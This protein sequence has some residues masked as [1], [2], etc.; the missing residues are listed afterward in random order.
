MT[1]NSTENEKLVNGSFF[2]HCLEYLKFKKGETSIQELAKTNGALF[3]DEHR[4][5]P[6]NDLVKI[7]NDVLK[8]IYG[9]PTS[10]GYYD[11]G[12][13]TFDSFAHTLIGATLTNMISSP[14]QIVESLQVLWSSVV[15]F[16]TRK[17]IQIDEKKGTALIEI[18]DDPRNPAYIQGI[19]EAALIKVKASHPK[20]HILNKSDSSYQVEVSWDPK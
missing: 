20:T 11:L 13:F 3:F 2:I 14:K 9:N 7:Q 18:T 1:E 15:N 4:M 16:G 10:E 6:L 17:L 5:Y 8:I 19:L 12:K